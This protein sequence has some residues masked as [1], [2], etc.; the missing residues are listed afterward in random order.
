MD[1]N[2]VGKW[3]IYREV[4]QY[5][6]PRRKPVSPLSPVGNI[7]SD[8]SVNTA[9]GYVG[10]NWQHIDPPSQTNDA[11]LSIAIF[12]T[13]AARLSARIYKICTPPSTGIVDN[14]VARTSADARRSLRGAVFRGPPH[15][16][17]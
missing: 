12:S 17:S 7:L 10:N 8:S 2:P 13:A 15:S 16:P 14:V 4:R 1:H 9:S 3:T 5:I 6:C 11:I